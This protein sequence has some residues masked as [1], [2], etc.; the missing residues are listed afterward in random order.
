MSSKNVNAIATSVI[1]FVTIIAA[2]VGFYINLK[3]TFTI[4]W[5]IYLESVFVVI[6]LF[7]IIWV[8]TKVVKK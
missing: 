6:I 4:K 3:S 8:K 2:M 1:A 5:I 7:F